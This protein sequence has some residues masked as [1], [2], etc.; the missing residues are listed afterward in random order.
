MPNVWVEL[1]VPGLLGF[2]LGVLVGPM[3]REKIEDL[4]WMIRDKM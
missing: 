3:L 2:G 1:V 4:Y